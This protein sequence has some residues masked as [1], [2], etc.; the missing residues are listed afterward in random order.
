MQKQK[1]NKRQKTVT[2][3]KILNRLNDIENNL[4]ETKWFDLYDAAEQVRTSPASNY[5]VTPIA[6]A[7]QPFNRNGDQVAA[8]RLEMR[9]SCS[10]PSGQRTPCWLRR[11]VY[12]DRQANMADNS[13]FTTG[14]VQSAL[15]ETLI[16]GVPAYLAPY[17]H[18]ARDRYR[19]LSDKTFSIK[20]IAVSTYTNVQPSVESAA[21]NTPLNEVFQCNLNHLRIK[22][23]SSA[24]TFPITNAIK[25]AF[26]SS[27]VG[28]DEAPVVELTTRLYYKDA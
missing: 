2:N 27:V 23:G 7:D 13:V 14:G 15:L 20:Q 24:A 25:V 10:T 18:L 12:V 3:R 26:V 4:M 16:T 28:A 5:H 1:N 11:I 22:Y 8:T 19:V 17:N 21:W 6:Q 9:W